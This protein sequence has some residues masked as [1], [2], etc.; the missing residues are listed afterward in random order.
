MRKDFDGRDSGRER[1]DLLVL[2]ATLL[3]YIAEEFAIPVCI[4]KPC[5][6]LYSTL[7]L[8]WTHRHGIFCVR[9]HF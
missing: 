2:E 5:I 3:K 8:L 7:D 6:E 1:S 4:L 9:K